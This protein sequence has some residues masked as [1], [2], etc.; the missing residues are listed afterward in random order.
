MIGLNDLTQFQQYSG[1][2]TRDNVGVRQSDEGPVHSRTHSRRA[3]DAQQHQV[4]H[5][6]RLRVQG[7]FCLSEN[8]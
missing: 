6:E 2:S 3:G 7:N 8:N 1:A 4:L 5:V